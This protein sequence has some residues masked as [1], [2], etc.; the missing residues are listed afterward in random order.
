MKKLIS[1]DRLSHESTFLHSFLSS[2][3]S[4]NIEYCVERNYENYPE[5]ITGDVDLIV[6]NSDLSEIIELVIKIGKKLG[7]SAF[8]VYPSKNISYVGFY[9]YDLTDRFVL[10]FEFFSGGVFRGLEFLSS[11]E[12][13]SKRIKYNEVWKPHPAHELILTLFHHLLYNGKVYQKYM[14]RICKLYS[15][16]KNDLYPEIRKIYGKNLTNEILQLIGEQDWLGIEKIAP[17]IRRSFYVSALINNPLK[18]FSNIIEL[19]SAL[20]NKPKGLLISFV[21]KESIFLALI[22]DFITLAIKWHIFIPPNRVLV[23][24]KSKSFLKEVNRIINS[25]GVAIT[26]NKTSQLKKHNLRHISKFIEVEVREET[27]CHFRKTNENKVIS[28]SE[29]NARTLWL[30]ILNFL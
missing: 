11:E 15:E 26:I 19:I 6:S 7:W 4:K 8:L 2:L 17:K 3:N 21:G 24:P 14:D 28:I 30:E 13:L 22:D 5:Q 27:I 1:K 16:S 20:N 10:V 29:V 12:I 18:S 9:K 25:G 23:N